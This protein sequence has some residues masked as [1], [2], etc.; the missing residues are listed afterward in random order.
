MIDHSVATARPPGC[1]DDLE[2]NAY[3]EKKLTTRRASSSDETVRLIPP[4]PL[5]LEQALELIRDDECVE[6]APKSIRLRKGELSAQKRQTAVSRAKRAAALLSVAM[7]RC[8]IEQEARTLAD[9]PSAEK[10]GDYRTLT[11]GGGFAGL[12]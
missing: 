3:R 8:L 9:L 7:A 1:A 12:R 5:S 4:R 2:V 11:Y 6:V 10:N